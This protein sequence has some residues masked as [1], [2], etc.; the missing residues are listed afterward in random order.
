MKVKFLI[1][2]IFIS[3]TSF[4][5]EEFTIV[6]QNP[7]TPVKI[8]EENTCWV[9]ATCSFL[10]SELLRIG[11][12]NCDLSEDY[13][14]YYG[15]IDKANNYILRE[16]NTRFGQGGVAGDVIRIIKDEGILPNG[17]F[18]IDSMRYFGEINEVC[19]SY[20]N[21]LI[22]YKD[23]YGF[24]RGN[25]K[26]QYL[27]L[28]NSYFDELPKEFKIDSQTYTAKSF[29]KFLGLN[30]DDYISITS[31]THH[32]F[33]KYFVLE[34]MDN[35]AS[36]LYYNVELDK[37]MQIIDS[38][39]LSGNTLLWGGDFSDQ[40]FS[41]KVK[42]YAVL[43]DKWVDE[44][45]LTTSISEMRVTQQLRQSAYENLET[46]DDHLMHMIGIAKDKSGRKFY[47]LKDSG[48]G[49]EGPYKGYIYLSENYVKMKT[50]SIMVNKNDIPLTI[51]KD[52]Y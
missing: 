40:G 11:K 30:M 24:L 51:K 35:Y 29:T 13:I 22:K 18:R 23:R 19:S 17:Y 10:E 9:Y 38:T 39:I 14:I 48:G 42:G 2:S 21:T 7:S 25:W 27:A 44:N 26:N 37:L 33:H 16:G 8:Q 34:T 32:P 41:E 6:I 45:N 43:P 12:E 52:L 47:L 15:Y 3:L 5:Q 1:I 31:F 50:V 46:T 36:N 20:L 28:L 49:M 4:S